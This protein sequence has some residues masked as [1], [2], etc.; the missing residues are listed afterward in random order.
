[1]ITAAESRATFWKYPP[2]SAWTVYVT[3]G[4]KDVPVHKSAE[5]EYTL[6]KIN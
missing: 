2:G 4:K 5:G 3:I 6:G 1:M